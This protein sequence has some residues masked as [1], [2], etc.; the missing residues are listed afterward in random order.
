MI[1]EI[2]PMQSDKKLSFG[3]STLPDW[4]VKAGEP[5]SQAGI[6]KGLMV[7]LD[8]HTDLLSEGSVDSDFEGFVV[9]ISKRESFPMTFDKGFLIKPGK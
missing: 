3:N 9:L 4:Y 8:A 7:M 2:D 1:G 5:K 6:N